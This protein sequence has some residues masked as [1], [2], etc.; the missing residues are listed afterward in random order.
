M[1]DWVAPRQLRNARCRRKAASHSSR[2]TPSRWSPSPEQ[3]SAG[4]S[5]SRR[6][7]WPRLRQA[8][9]LDRRTPRL[10]VVQL[11]DGTNLDS[12]DAGGG[13]SRGQRARLVHVLGLD[14]EEAPDLLLGLGEWAVRDGGL[15]AA[16][17]DRAGR[18]P[19]L[20]RVRGDVV[21]A[22]PD[23]FRVVESRVHE[24]LHL[25]PRQF[26]QGLLVVEDQEQEF[27]SSRSS[28]GRRREAAP[29][30]RENLFPSSATSIT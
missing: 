2:S 19:P 12:A 23:L 7:A 13:K 27:H 5:Y 16:D 1:P 29:A 28:M 11:L 8:A 3:T 22:L 6:R 26:V 15:A 24:G 25:L 17:P 14:E 9:P 4:S 18:P 20:E 21:A 30:G 10:G